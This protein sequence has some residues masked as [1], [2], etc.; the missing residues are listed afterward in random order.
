M[1]MKETLQAIFLWWVVWN[2]LDHAWAKVG[3][4]CPGLT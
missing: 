3:A 1:K 4:M 2:V